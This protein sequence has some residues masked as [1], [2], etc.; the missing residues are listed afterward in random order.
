MRVCLAVQV[1]STSDRAGRVAEVCGLAE[2]VGGKGTDAGSEVWSHS[3]RLRS[4]R[5]DRGVG[6]APPPR[7][8]GPRPGER[9]PPRAM[10]AG[11]ART[12]LGRRGLFGGGRAERLPPAAEHALPSAG[13]PGR[14]LV[15]VL[16]KESGRSRG[17]R[18]P[19]FHKTGR[20]DDDSAL[21]PLLPR[22]SRPPLPPRGDPG[23]SH[24]PVCVD[25]GPS[26][27]ACW[28]LR[29]VL[30]VVEEEEGS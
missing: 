2:G 19:E 15:A 21:L 30:A 4:G 24:S 8:R 3:G 22:A 6:L 1:G 23:V 29:V 5:G 16:K 13:R 7:I 18:R 25:P 17:W 26:E 27:V 10:P 14:A 28:R 11:A 9:L 12:R 20:R